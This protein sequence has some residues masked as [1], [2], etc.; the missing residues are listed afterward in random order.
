M[1]KEIIWTNRAIRELHEM[2]D[3]LQENHSLQAA[4]N[5]LAE[6]NKRLGFL[7][8]FP[9]AGQKAKKAKT[10]RFIPIGQNRRMFYRVHGRK[11][12]VVWFFDTRQ[13]PDKSLF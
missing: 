2:T 7:E 3:Y 12:V 13:H 5:L 9:E 6:I 8:K 10:V 11:L 1:V 4:I